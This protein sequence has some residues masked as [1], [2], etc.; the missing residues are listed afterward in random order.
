MAICYKTLFEVKLLH[1]YY[2]TK[3]DGESIFDFPLQKD[4]MDFLLDRFSKDDKNIHN[5]TT[6][7]IPETAKQFFK[8]HRL[9]LLPTYAGFKIVTEVLTQTLGDGTKI[10]RPKISLPEDSN[11]TVLIKD[12]GEV[13]EFTNG[14]INRFI[15]S[16]YYFSNEE[17]SGAK[18]YPFLS[19][20]ISAFDASQNYEQG[21]MALHNP[22]DNRIFFR[23]S[24]NALQWINV[25][26]SGYANENDRIVVSLGF[27][28]TLKDSENITDLS[29]NL[30]DA[31]SQSVVTYQFTQ[32]A[33]IQKVRINVPRKDVRT[34]N[35]TFPASDLVYTVHLTSS[36]GFDKT[37]RVVFYDA[38]RNDSNVWGIVHIKNTSG[39]TDF[40]LLDAG[41]F[42]HTRRKSDG[43]Y[44]PV[45]PIFEIPIKSK[46]PFWRYVHY[47][48]AAFQNNLHPNHLEIISGR[49]VTKTPRPLSYSPL[50]FKK[51]DNSP[52]YLPSPRLSPLR[53]EDG[54]LYADIYVSES[55]DLFPSGP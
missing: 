25:T 3:S 42:L 15:D 9:K 33:P 10:Y 55:S 27:Y 34:I 37:V 41:G 29:V 23:D 21:E 28:C 13:S 40:N 51:P 14:R 47:E 38:D 18:V 50:F 43:T 45:H 11:I 39:N 30:L 26:G 5:E 49:L 44:D 24:S 1:E 48:G 4:R 22:N 53:V 2:L 7:D 46:L 36:N 52:Y 6:F 54:K 16:K 35:D 20:A 8:G 12:K 19:N 17:F 32:L 31:N